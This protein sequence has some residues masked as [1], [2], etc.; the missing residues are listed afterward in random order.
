MF[1]FDSSVVFEVSLCLLEC[2]LEVFDKLI[3]FL[4]GFFQ[5]CELVFLLLVCRLLLILLH[6][7]KHPFKLLL[8]YNFTPF[9]SLLL[10]VSF[11]LSL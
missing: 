9:Q 5:F 11:E 10:A 8:I 6:V 3:T 1:H 4:L 7:S 2:V